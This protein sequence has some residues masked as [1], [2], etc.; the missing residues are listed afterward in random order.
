MKNLA[1]Y[2]GILGAL[3]LGVMCV[4]WIATGTIF[5]SGL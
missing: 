5:S 2:L 3:L 1:V 4:I